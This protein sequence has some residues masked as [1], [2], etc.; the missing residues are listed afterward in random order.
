[1]LVTLLL[2][3]L[4]ATPL[5]S[6][7]ISSVQLTRVTS[8]AFFIAAALSFNAYYV[9]TLESGVS[10]YSGL[11]HVS[12]VSMAVEMFIFVIGGVILLSPWPT[13]TPKVGKVEKA[14]QKDESPIAEYSIIVVFSTIGASFL[15]SST[16]LVSLYLAIELQSFA[17]YILSALYRNNES[18]TAAGLKY[19]LLGA[20][21]SALIL[22]GSSLIYGYTGLTNVDAISNLISVSTSESSVTQGVIL[23]IVIMSVGFLFKIASAPFH[24]WAPDVYDGVPTIVTTWIAV[25]P[26]ISIFVLLLTLHG[27]T[28]N[29]GLSLGD[30]AVLQGL[31]VWQA[32]LLVSSLLSLII[33]TVVGL[34]QF[35]IKRLLAYST[36]SHV[37]FMLLGL[38]VSGQESIDA[39]LFYLIQYTLTSVNAFF[40][41]LAF[42]YLI[43]AGRKIRD[44]NNDIQF[45][46]ELSG[47]F[48]QN[49]ILALSM[50]ICLFSMAGIP[51]LMGFF[52][53]YAVLYS[54]IHNG[55]YFI[56]LVAILA[57]VVSAAYYLR[58]VRVLY[59]SPAP[60]FD[61]VVSVFEETSFLISDQK[62]TA[63]PGQVVDKDQFITSSHAYIIAV[64]TVFIVLFV[65]QPSLILNSTQ[66]MAMSIY[67][68]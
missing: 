50:I 4:I 3:L 14:G 13:F 22:L 44:Q 21:S 2:S 12:T 19:F 34:A 35:R 55:Y 58:I 28:Q 32:L 60:V 64:L 63:E 20:L 42:G 24:N 31:N 29:A 10:L 61:K 38:A 39:F 27:L 41:L 16:D 59:F 37:G 26:K 53:K 48:R 47:Q 23:G 52:A 17:V 49:P 7:K 67:G 8:I 5:S 18:A 15:V 51:P 66:L 25:M 33:G 46:S 11:F 68:Y 9:N 62:Q 57:S 45:I 1:M 43:N 6:S 56:S 65:L 30:I 40:V 54:A 36:I